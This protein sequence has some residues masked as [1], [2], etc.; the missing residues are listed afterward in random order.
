MDG[1]GKGDT[2]CLPPLEIPEVPSH[3]SASLIEYYL[4][5]MIRQRLASPRDVHPIPLL[6]A[7]LGPVYGMRLC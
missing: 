3:N 1:D 2:R 4:V 6:P 7:F 5:A